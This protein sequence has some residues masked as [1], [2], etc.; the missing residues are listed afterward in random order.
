MK[1]LFL[2]ILHDIFALISTISL[3]PEH[4]LIFNLLRNYDKRIKPKKNLT[5][6]NRMTI[7]N[8]VD[9]DE[10]H[11]TIKL[12]LWSTQSWNDPLLIWNPD[13]YNNTEHINIPALE[14]W[15]PDWHIFN[16]IDSS[17]SMSMERVNARVMFNGNVLVDF[18]KVRLNNRLIH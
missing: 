12:L 10:L 3:L 8:L 1:Y 14:I 15:L 17:D 13:D 11:E 2:F 4:E 18:Y 16:Q 5:V 9:V 6:M 7:Y